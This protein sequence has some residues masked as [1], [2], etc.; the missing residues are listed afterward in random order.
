MLLLF[1]VILTVIGMCYALPRPDDSEL[2]TMAD[3]SQV[4]VRRKRKD[5]DSG[6]GFIG[7][8]GGDGSGGGGGGGCDG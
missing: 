1:V 4:K 7:G 3:G 8:G 2:M 5:G 6:G